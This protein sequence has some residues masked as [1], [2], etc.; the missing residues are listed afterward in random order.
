MMIVKVRTSVN[1]VFVAELRAIALY[2]EGGC[3]YVGLLADWDAA[4]RITI[5]AD[6][7]FRRIAE[8]LRTGE[9]SVD[10]T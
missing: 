5:S 4:E 8:A 2:E 9:V 1:H 10:L 6:E 7:A 3:C